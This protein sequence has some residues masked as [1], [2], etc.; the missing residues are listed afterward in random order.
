MRGILLLTLLQQNRQNRQNFLSETAAATTAATTATTKAPAAIA[1]T[2]ATAAAA[3]TTKATKATAAL[4]PQFTGA[5]NL[6]WVSGVLMSWSDLGLTTVNRNL[7]ILSL[8]GNYVNL[9]GA[10]LLSR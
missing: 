8:I 10:S 9:A 4:G 5:G 2:A 1:T 6:Q 3:T 7:H